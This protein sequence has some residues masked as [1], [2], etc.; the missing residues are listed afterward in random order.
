MLCLRIVSRRFFFLWSSWFT[1]ANHW[2][3]GPRSAVGNMSGHRCGS[4]CKSK[5]CEFD[6]GPV[7]YFRGDWAWN[8]SFSSLPLNHSRSVVISYKRNYVQEVLV[9]LPRKSVVR[10]TD[11]PAMTL[12]DDLES[13]ASKQTQDEW[14]NLDRLLNQNSR[15]KQQ[16]HFALLTCF[17]RDNAFQNVCNIGC[18]QAHQYITQNGVDYKIND[19]ITN[20]PAYSTLKQNNISFILQPTLRRFLKLA[21]KIWCQFVSNLQRYDTISAH[22][23][24]CVL[25]FA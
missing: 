11:R 5:G 12:A 4:D 20:V 22:V 13:K 9:N 1:Q 21:S 23:P 19:I 15:S 24:K 14:N 6:P 3:I 10:W 18:N 16:K 17:G 2:V 7:P 8:R 25:H